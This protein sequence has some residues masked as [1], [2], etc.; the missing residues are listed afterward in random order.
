MPPT[1]GTTKLKKTSRMEEAKDLAAIHDNEA[2]PILRTPDGCATLTKEIPEDWDKE[3]VKLLGEIEP[4][5]SLVRR[6]AARA[7]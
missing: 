2:V 5:W 6:R 3:T 4:P 7:T 1:S